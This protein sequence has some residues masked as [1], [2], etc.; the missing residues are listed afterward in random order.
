MSNDAN[1]TNETGN[2][3]PNGNPDE[4]VTAQP[5]AQ[6][7][8]ASAQKTEEHAPINH[9]HIALLHNFNNI[10][11]RMK[12]LAGH[13]ERSALDMFARGWIDVCQD[14]VIVTAKGKALIKHLEEQANNFVHNL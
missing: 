4:V 1:N 12:D 8:D 6:F 14:E 13:A 9:H 5:T 2:E 3:F 10:V 7:P 11:I